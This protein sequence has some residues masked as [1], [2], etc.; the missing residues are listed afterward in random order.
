MSNEAKAIL[1]IEP[2]LRTQEQCHVALV[3]M[4]QAVTAFSEFPIKMQKSLTKVGWY[5]Q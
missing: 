4:N 1:S 2:E 3:S 5:E